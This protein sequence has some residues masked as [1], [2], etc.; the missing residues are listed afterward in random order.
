MDTDL[1]PLGSLPSGWTTVP[2]WKY[3]RR[4]KRTGFAEKELLSVYRDHGV[5]PK[6][7]R[8]DNHNVESEDLSAYQLVEVGDLVVNKM[9]AWQGSVALSAYEGIVSPAYFVYQMIGQGHAKYFHYLLRSAP[10]ISAYNKISKGV[11]VGQWDLEPQEFRKLPLILP[12]LESQI[13]IANYLEEKI[14]SAAPLVDTQLEILKMLDK[15]KSAVIRSYIFGEDI[16][17][18]EGALP[19]GVVGG[20]LAPDFT[21]NRDGWRTIPVRSIFKFKKDEVGD[22]WSTTQLLSLTKRGVISRDID[23]G[24]GKYPESFEGYQ[25][26]NEGD[27]VFC[28]FDVEE[29]PRTVG[30]V[31]QEGMITSAYTRVILNQSIAI[32]KFVEYLFI[33]LDDEKS[34][35]P[36][37][38]GLRNTIPAELLRATLISLPSLNEQQNIVNE[39]DAELLEISRLQDKVGALSDLVRVRNSSLISDVVTG[40][41]VF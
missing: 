12:P 6:S 37:Y 34:F 41:K 26:V 2:V 3:F 19:S 4:N 9:K 18:T 32:G 28:L 30:L 17:S 35:K 25:K 7:S 5:I 40:K 1:L 15:R 22:S 38:S 11:R 24:V 36:F 8:S 33:A 21:V 23:S 39:I 27:L 14:A 31:R 20:R 10:Y 16:S 29:T 13:R